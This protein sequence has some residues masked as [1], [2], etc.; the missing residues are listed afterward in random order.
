MK[1]L[2]RDV[3][4]L[5]RMLD[6]GMVESGVRRIGAEQEFFLVDSAFRPAPMAQKI[7][8]TMNEPLFEH[9]LGLYNLECSVDPVLFGGDCLSRM[10]RQLAE[11]VASAREAA[12]AHDTHLVLTG[13]LPTI[14]KSDL[15]LHNQTPDPRYKLLNDTLSALRGD[16]YE[17]NIKGA[18]EVIL[19]H[20][21]VMLESA[22]TSFQVHFQV[23]P[24]EF[25][26]LYNIAQ[27]VCAPVLACAS[28]SP[29][30]FGKRLWRETRIAL[31]QQ[32][33]DTRQSSSTMR[34]VKPRVSFGS[35]WVEDS[36]LEIFRE[37]IARFRVLFAIELDEDPLDVIERGEAPN[38]GA[39]R[40]HN[41]TVYRWNRACYGISEGRP[42][43]RIE[44]RVL[45]SGP[46]P[47]DEMAN[48]AFW[49]GMMSG[50]VAHYGDVTARL[51]FGDARGN[52]FAAARGGLD[53]SFSWLDGSTHTAR[54]L[55]LRELL[56]LAREGLQASNI[57]H[58]DIDRYLDVMRQRVESKRTGASWLLRSYSAIKKNTNNTSEALSALTA[59][60]IKR[61][62]EGRPIH[63]WPLAEIEESASWK[64]NHLR[65][66]QYMSR[67]LFTLNYD[68]PV[69][70]AASLMTWHHIHWIPVE[71]NEHHLV[72][73]V[74][75]DMLLKVFSDPAYED[76]LSSMTVSEIMDTNVSMIHPDTLT[77]DAVHLM[78]DK[79]HACLPVVEEGK[80]VGMITERDV[81]DIARDLLEERLMAEDD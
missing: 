21:D 20:Q 53:A 74:T 2:L 78:Y 54:D 24:E 27:V 5:E 63:E 56:P 51:D 22:N 39:L 52:F 19:K 64:H 4:A 35:G 7:L 59:A 65:V 16:A 37:D 79:R 73:L 12:L 17:I 6:A 45:P 68:E 14:E 48:A 18:D 36:V 40:L 32:S 26:K 67:D 71:D 81:L 49:F 44:N 69:E 25:A 30:L 1:Q 34:E 15:G 11:L 43:L 42:H 72:G 9:E 33:V 31:F 47:L 57:D 13:I 28:N 75:H 66:S 61:Q 10:E 41:S 60:T 70:F 55:I 77:L 29:L 23:G 62:A 46:T 58:E 80:L 50:V 8:A 38:L 76:K 3:R